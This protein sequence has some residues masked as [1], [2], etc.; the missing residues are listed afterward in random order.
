VAKARWGVQP[1]PE[2]KGAVGCLYC[3]HCTHG[4]VRHGVLGDKDNASA[5][6]TLE[7]DVALSGKQASVGW[8]RPW[9]LGGLFARQSVKA[10]ST[11]GMQSTRYER[12]QWPSRAISAA[13]ARCTPRE[14]GS[15]HGQGTILRLPRHG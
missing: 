2:G 11:L 4:G 8:Q 6:R 12:L 15:S 3:M 13:K 10:C 1:V 7:R 9:A 5:P 14:L